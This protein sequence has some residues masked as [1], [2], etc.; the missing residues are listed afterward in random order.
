MSKRTG[1]TLVEL[2]V[3]L[4]IIGVLVALLLPAVQAAR[5]AARRMS[6]QNNLKQIVLS[7]QNYHDQF[8]VLPPG[9]IAHDIP[10]AAPSTNETGTGYGWFTLLLPFIEQRSLHRELDFKAD[11]REP[12]NLEHGSIAFG[13]NQCPT[14]P[15]SSYGASFVVTSGGRD[16]QLGRA[17]YVGMY[18][19]GDVTLRPGAPTGPGVLYRNSAV[20]MAMIH[21]GTSH[22]IV[23]GE[24]AQQHRFTDDGSMVDASSTWYAAV[25]GVSRPAG[26]RG[27]AADRMEG[28]GSLVLATVGQPA[29]DGLPEL[30]NVPNTTNHIVGLSSQHGYGVNAAACDGAVHFVH[31]TIDYAVY[32]SLGERADA[33][34]S[35]GFGR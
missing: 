35:G 30:H 23:V 20:R 2:L 27:V 12:R 14:D 6:C 5:E 11:C 3:V 17:S 33:R 21:D 25:P 29:A 32:R 28:P 24:R 34:L 4:T 31:K 8:E 15:L 1:F 7:L 26:L 19:Y 22:T 16:L 9:Y 13:A 18:G 10:E